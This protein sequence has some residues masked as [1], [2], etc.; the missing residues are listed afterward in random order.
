M[1]EPARRGDP[2]VR[3]PAIAPELAVVRRP[4]DTVSTWAV[5]SVPVVAL[6][7]AQVWVP[8]DSDATAICPFRR[9]TGGW[10]PFCG[11][12]RASVQLLRGD[13]ADAFS[14][15]P[16][17]AP[18]LVSVVAVWLIVLSRRV[19]LSRWAPPWLTRRLLTVLATTEAIVFVGVWLTRLAL[20]DIPRPF[21]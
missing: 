4:L 19:D 20:A 15:H 10:C 18:A 9:V 2:H 5:A 6:G 13:V 1:T 11:L 14:Y 3:T 17:V 7:L 16:L 21:T 12:T 8:S